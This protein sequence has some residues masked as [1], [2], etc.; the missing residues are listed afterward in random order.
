MPKHSSQ[1]QFCTSKLHLEHLEHFPFKDLLISLHFWPISPNPMA[2]QTARGSQLFGSSKVHPRSI[3]VLYQ[4]VGP[5]CPPAETRQ[6][7][8]SPRLSSPTFLHNLTNPPRRPPTHFR[9]WRHRYPPRNVL[10]FHFYSR[11][12]RRGHLA[13]KDRHLALYH[14]RQNKGG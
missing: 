2:I 7:C 1:L 3:Q 8:I 14:G 9:P 10:P 4:N 5:F 13:G 11:A 6:A 12:S